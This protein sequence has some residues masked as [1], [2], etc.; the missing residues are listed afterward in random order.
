MYLY[1]RQIQI[2]SKELLGYLTF[3][4]MVHQANLG[5]ISNYPSPGGGL[6]LFYW[7]TARCSHFT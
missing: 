4:K 6:K 2:G 3:K 5:V 7:E 1:N